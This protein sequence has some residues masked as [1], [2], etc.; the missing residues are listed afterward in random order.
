MT[1]DELADADAE[2]KGLECL[3]GDIFISMGVC[4]T[5]VPGYILLPSSLYSFLVE[6]TD[7]LG[8]GNL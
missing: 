5:S 6:I 7:Q 8:K 4:Y 1:V 2:Y 3:V